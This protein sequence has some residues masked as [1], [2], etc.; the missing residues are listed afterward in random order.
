MIHA[1]PWWRNDPLDALAVKSPCDLMLA[2]SKASLA[3]LEQLRPKVMKRL[4]YNGTPIRD[5]SAEDAQQARAELGIRDG[6]VL[7]GVFGRL[8][9]W[10]GQDVFVE[11]AAAVAAGSRRRGS[12][13]SGVRSS[14]RA[15]V[16]GGPEAARRR[17][18]PH[19]PPDLTA[20]ARTWR[21]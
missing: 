1:H 15:R 19:G 9:R 14:V 4:L 7:F 6:E 10:K 18:E 16:P 3:T 21:G 11:A 13:W 8:Q 12:R 20:S 2:V 17:A 5:V